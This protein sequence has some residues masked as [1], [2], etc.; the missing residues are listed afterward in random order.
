MVALLRPLFELCLLRRGPQDLPYSPPAV[1]LF[2]FA[3]MALQVA[4]GAATEAPPG[5]L[6]ARVGV[7]AFMLFGVTQA[8]LNLRGLRN[9]AAQT[10]L[11]LAGSGLLFTLAMLPAALALRPYLDVDQPPASAMLPGLAALVLF[12]WKL[13]VEA[14]IWRQALEI[15]RGQALALAIALVLLELMLL[16]WLAPPV[17]AAAA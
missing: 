16:V 3:L 9:R 2:A 12:V 8:L 6:A 17:P 13:R 4:M 10:L 15:R 7:T 11:A 14:A 1:A 5:Q